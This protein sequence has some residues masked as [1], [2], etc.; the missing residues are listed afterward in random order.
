MNDTHTCGMD[1]P[2]IHFEAPTPRQLGYR[3]PAEWEEHAATWLTWPRPEG[4]SFPGAFQEASAIWARI[5]GVLCENEQVHINVFD[6]EHREL[7]MR[8]L[9]RAGLSGKIQR[10]IFLH[11]FPAYEPWVRDHGPVFLKNESSTCEASL[12]VVDWNYNAWG[13]KY[14]PYHLDDEVPKHVSNL[15]EL[16]LFQPGIV[17]EGG[18]LDVNGCGD[19]LTTRSCL[20]NPNRNPSLSEQDIETYLREFLG[21]ERIHWLGDGIEGDDTDGHVDDLSRFVAEDVIVTVIEDDPS[22]K[23]YTPLMEN[24]ERLLHLRGARGPFRIVTLPM[25]PRIERDGMRLP[26]SYANFYIANSVVI[27][28]VFKAP[29]DREALVTLAELFPGRKIYALDATDLIWGLGAVH[30]I[31]Q[32]Q[33]AVKKSR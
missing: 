22:D 2:P 28:P 27:V 13:G 21:V 9:D 5:T 7:V 31:T 29:S 8:E 23:N 4:I 16:P 12:A 24:Y 20:L 19:L 11:P 17:M 18:S 3:M 30:C 6:A 10:S 14:P 15:L 25:P 33:P 32:Q 26:A 1:K